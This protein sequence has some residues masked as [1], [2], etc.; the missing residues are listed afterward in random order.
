MGCR[1]FNTSPQQSTKSQDQSLFKSYRME[2]LLKKIRMDFSSKFRNFDHEV[3]A[4][5]YIPLKD[6][7]A[8]DGKKSHSSSK[9]EQVKPTERRKI[10][11]KFFNFPIW[12]L[13][14]PGYGNMGNMA[15][16][17][18]AQ[19]VDLTD[20]VAEDGSKPHS[21]SKGQPDKPTK[22]KTSIK[23]TSNNMKTRL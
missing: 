18:L 4:Q 20:L 1:Q 3:R 21:C 6:L 9:G 2:K 8:E 14:S 17:T 13:C 10:S 12:E 19:N 5:E 22:L 11:I 23:N 16:L 15:Y 7:V